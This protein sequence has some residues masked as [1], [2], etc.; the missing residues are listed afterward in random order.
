V[1]CGHCSADRTNRSPGQRAYCSTMPAARETANRGT[2]A[3]A[4]RPSTESA[5]PGVIRI[6]TGGQRQYDA[7]R[8]SGTCDQTRHDPEISS[9]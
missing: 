7:E 4:N 8:Y 5:L 6:T 2:C 3:R 1:R 9:E